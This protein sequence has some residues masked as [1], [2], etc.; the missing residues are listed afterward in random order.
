MRAI[1]DPINHPTLCDTITIHLNST[2][3]AHTSVYAQTFLLTSLE[4]V[5]LFY[6]QVFLIQNIIFQLNIATRLKPGANFLF[7]SVL[8]K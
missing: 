7:H 8:G 2:T 3:G 5:R 6:L 1:A 4:M